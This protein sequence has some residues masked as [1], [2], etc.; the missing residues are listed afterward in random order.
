MSKRNRQWRSALLITVLASS[1]LPADTTKATTPI[2]V[3]IGTALDDPTGIAALRFRDRVNETLG[4]QVIVRIFPRGTLGSE[5]AIMEGALGGD[6]DVAA[7]SNVVLAN[8]VPELHVLD[9]PFGLTST[10]HAWRVL[11]GPIGAELNAKLNERGLRVMGWAY[12]GSRQLMFRDAAATTPDTL[13]GMKIRVPANPI[14]AETVEAWGATSTT[15]AWPEVYLALSQGVVDGIETAAGPSFD[16]KHYEVAKYL[17]RTDHV[18]YF[19]VWVVSE[20]RWKAWP[21]AI[22][23]A[24]AAA[25]H[26]AAM[27]NRRLRLE[28]EKSIF[29]QFEQKG[30]TVIRPDVDAFRDSVTGVVQKYSRE[31]AELLERIVACK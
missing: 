13:R 1:C 3:A 16:Q 4:D 22:R 18:I 14:Y 29:R 21:E 27:L 10:D 31:Y 30:V 12:A 17:V 15:V 20:R 26:E 9:V 25:A 6:I 2:R 28:N 8:L 5:T 24:V 7:I 19:H 23:D 11:D